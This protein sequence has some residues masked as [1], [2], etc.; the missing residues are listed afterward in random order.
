MLNKVV[1]IIILF[2]DV[3]LLFAIVCVYFVAELRLPL[4]KIESLEVHLVYVM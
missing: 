1:S 2:N 4:A 3:P